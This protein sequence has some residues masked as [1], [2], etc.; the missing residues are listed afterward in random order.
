MKTSF[1]NVVHGKFTPKSTE[2]K[3]GT[4]TR[5]TSIKVQYEH[6]YF[7]ETGV[8]TGGTKRG[9]PYFE[10]C[11]FDFRGGLEIEK[12]KGFRAV[13]GQGFYDMDNQD[14]KDL[15][16]TLKES[17]KKGYIPA[18]GCRESN[19]YVTINNKTDKKIKIRTGPAED[20]ESVESIAPGTKA[21]FPYLSLIGDP[22]EPDWYQISYG[23]KSGFWENVKDMVAQ[24]IYDGVQN[25]DPGLSKLEQGSKIL[26]KGKTYQAIRD[27]IK[28]EMVWAGNAEKGE[29]EPRTFF[30]FTFFEPKDGKPESF[31]KLH[32]PGTK[33]TLSLKEALNTG[34]VAQPVVQLFDIF[35][36][37]K[38]KISIRYYVNSCIIKKLHDKLI[39][40]SESSQAHD[41]EEYAEKNDV[42]ALMAELAASRL[43]IAELEKEGKLSDGVRVQRNNIV[44][45]NEADPKDIKAPTQEDLIKSKKSVSKALDALADSD[46]D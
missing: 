17:G 7:D 30:N 46:D 29:K 39:S 20:A 37:M 9:E 25:D 10:L 6:P 8:P 33:D 23:G 34:F 13:K 44:E 21:K 26:L 31:A 4:E 3:T 45:T 42:S 43:K 19:G 27:M 15:I 35:F 24:M 28:Q 1:R 38:D 14:T 18:K 22:D 2:I 11:D 12:K 40:S 32:I 36:D 5:Y 41:A 16:S